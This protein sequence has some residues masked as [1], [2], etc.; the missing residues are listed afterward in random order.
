MDN[1]HIITLQFWISR[2]VI[3]IRKK[4]ITSVAEFYAIYK[5]VD[6]GLK[7]KDVAFAEVHVTIVGEM[8]PLQSLGID[9]KKHQAESLMEEEEEQLW[10]TS[11]LGDHSPQ[12]LMDTMHSMP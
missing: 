12:A 8:K 9:A 11:Q 3:E 6:T 5:R 2:F 7:F 1:E 4:K 10:Q